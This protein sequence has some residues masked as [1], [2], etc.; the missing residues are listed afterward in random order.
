[1]KNKS[2]AEQESND[3]ED[4]EEVGPSAIE[5]LRE[6]HQKVQ[7]LFEEFE[8]ADNRSRQ[9]IADQALTELEIHAK[10]EEGLVYPAI[11]EA[12]DEEDMMDEALEEHHVAELLIKELRKMQPKDE[13]YRAKFTVLA[14]MVKHH[15]EEEES[16]MLPQAEETDIDMEELGQ[17]AMALKEKLLSKMQSGSSSKKKTSSASRSG[18]SRKRKAA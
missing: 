6:D 11:R 2:S 1:M 4:Q 7:A 5:L 15:I 14:E 13:R 8:G 10:L 12:L 16:D 18:K 9:R 17:E 3:Q